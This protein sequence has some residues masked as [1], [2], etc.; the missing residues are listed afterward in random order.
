MQGERNRDGDSPSLDHHKA[1]NHLVPLP[2]PFP[3]A[4]SKWMYPRVS[5]SVS[6][7]MSLLL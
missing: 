7:L 4:L 2:H 5:A 3:G 6:L 1:N